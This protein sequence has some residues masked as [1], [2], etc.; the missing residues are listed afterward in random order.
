MKETAGAKRSWV[1]ESEEEEHE[2]EQSCLFNGGFFFFP[3]LMTDALWEGYGRVG[4][5][6]GRKEGPIAWIQG[7]PRSADRVEMIPRGNSVDAGLPRLN[8]LPCPVNVCKSVEGLGSR[9]CRCVCVRACV[10][11]KLTSGGEAVH[12]QQRNKEPLLR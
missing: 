12:E 9:Y 3:F 11:L 4:V 10:L 6:S 7:D 1:N 8:V 2:T 5:G